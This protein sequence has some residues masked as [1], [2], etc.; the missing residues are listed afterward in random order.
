V[1]E[2][3]SEISRITDSS[4][5]STTR[6]TEISTRESGSLEGHTEKESSSYQMASN[7]RDNS[8]SEGHG[9]LELS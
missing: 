3:S 6:T 8:D 2:N 4:L 9:V 1:E 7:I 5:V